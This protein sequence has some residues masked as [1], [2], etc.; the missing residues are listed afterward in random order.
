MK[1]Q[2]GLEVDFRE[3]QILASRFDLFFWDLS[4]RIGRRMGGLEVEGGVEVV[5][6]VAVGEGRR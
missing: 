1:D 2:D 5:E 3:I 6:A 4:E